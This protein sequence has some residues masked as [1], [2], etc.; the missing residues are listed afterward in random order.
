M[1]NRHFNYVEPNR[2]IQMRENDRLANQNATNKLNEYVDVIKTAA[3][4]IKITSQI[5]KLIMFTKIKRY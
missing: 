1:N 5:A 2:W 4:F 3:T